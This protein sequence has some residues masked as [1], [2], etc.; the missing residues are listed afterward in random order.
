MMYINDVRLH[1]LEDYI[2]NPGL[3]K[4]SP[5]IPKCLK[6]LHPLL[7][8]F[9]IRFLSNDGTGAC[10]VRWTGVILGACPEDVA[11]AQ[12]WGLGPCP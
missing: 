3:I 10:P 11:M 8:S 4:L 6:L 9:I 5:K 7:P 2:C 1:Q 12:V